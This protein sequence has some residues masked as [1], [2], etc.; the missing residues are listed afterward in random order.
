M[1]SNN[2]RGKSPKSGGSKGDMSYDEK[3]YNSG[4]IR[5]LVKSEY[6]YYYVKNKNPVTKEDLDRILSLKLPPAWNNVWISGDKNSDIQ[7][8]GVDSKGRK[9]Y[10]YNAKHTVD[11]EKKKFLRLYEFIKSI[12]KLDRILKLHSKLHAYDKR[13][14]IVTMLQLVKELHF[15]VGKEQYAQ[16]NKS[17]GVSSMKK[18][19]LKIVSELIKF[20][21]KGKS[22]KRLSYSLRNPLVK[23]HLQLLLKLDGE[24]LFQYIDDNNNIRRVTD[25]DINQY[26]QTY[27]G[28][29]FSVKDFRTY[30][31]NYYFIKALL[32]E[33]KKH[34]NN[35]KKNI[36]NAIKISAKHLSHTRNISKKSYVM[37]YSVALYTSHPEFFVSRKYDDPQ[38]VLTD[39]LKSYKKNILH[40]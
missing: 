31:A 39:I 19:H 14:V 4:I 20:N 18:T 40:F 12:P 8:V 25:L 38:D 23:I 33:T 13:R 37:S 16:H 35:I 2:A 36:M 27:M 3:H 6:K 28:E 26:I 22:N 29:D 34:S 11:A 1:S 7:A 10:K 24:K 21:F 15:R 30:A 9:Q 5:V 32:N 17:Y